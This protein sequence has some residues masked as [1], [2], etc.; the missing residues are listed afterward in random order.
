MPRVQFWFSRIIHYSFIS[1]TSLV[2]L[3]SIAL[4]Y[5]RVVLINSSIYICVFIILETFF[6]RCNLGTFFKISFCLSIQTLFVSDLCLHAY[7][8]LNFKL[9][10]KYLHF[11]S[12]YT[13]VK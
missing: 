1:F 7:I 13:S 12:I 4:L 6:P 9:K 2:F 11:F 3:Y 8:A 10:R 5:L